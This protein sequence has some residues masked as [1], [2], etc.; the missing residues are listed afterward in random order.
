MAGG[1]TTSVATCWGRSNYYGG[2]EGGGNLSG[3][4]YTIPISVLMVVDEDGRRRQRRQWAAAGSG[5]QCQRRWTVT[6]G[7]LLPRCRWWRQG[8]RWQTMDDGQLKVG[9][10]QNYL[11]TKLWER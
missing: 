9:G 7:S 3:G 8:N 6:A 10:R 1:V 11:L 2:G 5:R 4:E